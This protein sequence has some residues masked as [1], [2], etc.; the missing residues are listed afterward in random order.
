MLQNRPEPKSS[1][2]EFLG[3]HYVTYAVVLNCMQRRLKQPEPRI[4][5]RDG[6]NTLADVID[7]ARQFFK[8]I[9]TTYFASSR[10]VAS[11]FRA[12]SRSRDRNTPPQTQSIH[13]NEPKRT[14]C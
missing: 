9:F 8:R 12:R 4:A 1:V 6:A 11:N 3:R 7:P 10:L 14:I 2:A 13:H 5:E